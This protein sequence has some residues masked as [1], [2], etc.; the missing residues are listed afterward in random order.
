LVRNHPF[1]E[2]NGKRF[3][4]PEAEATLKT[5]ALA[6]RELNEAGYA[7]WLRENSGRA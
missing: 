2:L 6:A 7:A 5:L 3:A 1:L 4:A